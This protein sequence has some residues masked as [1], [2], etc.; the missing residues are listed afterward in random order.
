MAGSSGWKW[1]P[2]RFRQKGWRPAQQGGK[3]TLGT[4]EQDT[5]WFRLSLT[6][7]ESGLDTFLKDT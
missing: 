2:D 5:G 6:V 4:G 1:K 7:C 3:E